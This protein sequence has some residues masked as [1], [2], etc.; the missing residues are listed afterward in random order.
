MQGRRQVRK[1]GGPWPK[2]L[3]GGATYTA[4]KGGCVI[5]FISVKI[6]GHGPPR[7]LYSPTLA[8]GV[9]HFYSESCDVFNIV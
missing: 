7:Y 5:Y 2:I 9:T 6:F 1:F 8:W 4:E 3:G